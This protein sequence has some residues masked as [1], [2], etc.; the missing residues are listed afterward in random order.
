M[1]LETVSTIYD[2]VAANPTS[3]DPLSQT[4]DHLRNLKT[5][6]LTSFASSI[7][8]QSSFQ[9]GKLILKVGGTTTSGA[10]S[11]SVTFTSAFPTTLLHA[12]PVLLSSGP[13][14]IIMSTG[15]QATTGFSAFASTPAGA[16]AAVSFSWLAVGY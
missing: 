8:T 14:A 13:V 15:N 10:G 16:G 11:A 4:D 7:G 9:L 2:L 3:G 6:L 1:A 12:I 5:A